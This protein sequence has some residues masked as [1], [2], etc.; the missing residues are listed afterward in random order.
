MVGRHGLSSNKSLHKSGS[1]VKIKNM[2]NPINPFIY[3][4]PVPPEKFIGREREV[5][6][7]L[8]RLANLYNRGGSMVSGSSGIGK[9]SLLHYLGAGEAR[10][11]WEQLNPEIVRFVYMPLGIISPFSEVRFWEFLFDE[12]NEW[13]GSIPSMEKIT[14]FLEAGKPPS[15]PSISKFFTKLGE[16]DENKFVV[17][18]LDGFDLL[19]KEIN[20]GDPKT[21]VGFLQTLRSLL[22]LPAPR[23]IS[24]ITS[25]EREMYDLF[26]DVQWFG[27]GFYSHMV[28][29][30]LGPFDEIQIDKLLD[31]YLR[32]TGIRFDDDDR[33]QLKQKSSGHPTKLQREA[34]RLF[35]KKESSL[36]TKIKQGDKKMDSALIGVITSASALLVEIARD[37]FKA[38]Q[39]QRQTEEPAAEAEPTK[40]TDA[41]APTTTT[42]TLPIEQEDQLKTILEAMDLASQKMKIDTIKSLVNQLES[43]KRTWNDFLE[44][45]A[46]PEASPVTK[47]ALKQARENEEKAIKEKSLSLKQ[48][49]EELTGR[50]IELAGLG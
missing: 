39:A 1:K 49:L 44:E 13:L 7:I 21:G 43:H 22:N 6:I 26:K 20:E 16:S 25:S 42:P 37:V 40:E 32:G 10:K 50:S 8:D 17:V 38:R 23:G 35:E 9:T 33:T 30:P 11:Q 31:S 46:K 4:P 45:E 28:N 34:H 29:L 12:L 3:G 27:S 2:T 47:I 48:H 36:K 5:D 19:I 14:G 41:S 18:L 24:L 15:R